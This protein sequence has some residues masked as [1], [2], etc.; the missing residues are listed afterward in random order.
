MR[1]TRKRDGRSDFLESDELFF[2]YQLAEQTKRTVAELTSGEPCPLS[3]SEY[4]MWSTFYK[5]KQ[6]YQ[7]QAMKK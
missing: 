5:I 4:F 3:L 6:L 1:R 2:T 7:D